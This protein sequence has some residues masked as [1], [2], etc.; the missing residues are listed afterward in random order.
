MQARGYQRWFFNREV[1]YLLGLF[2]LEEN[3]IDTKLT[4]NKLD[5]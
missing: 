1:K 3:K 5:S 4:D 2:Y